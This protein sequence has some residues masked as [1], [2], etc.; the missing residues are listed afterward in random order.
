MPASR[1]AITS[2]YMISADGEE[3]R[4]QDRGTGGLR[5]R[6]R[7]RRSGNA[8]SCRRR[9]ARQ[10]CCA[11]RARRFI[12]ARCPALRAGWRGASVC[13]VG[14]AHFVGAA[15][16]RILARLAG[17][18]ADIGGELPDLV[19]G[20][21]PAPRRHAVGAAFGDRRGD[22][23][24]A[25]AVAPLVVHQRRAHAAAAMGMAADAIHLRVEQLALGDRRGIVVVELGARG[26]SGGGAPPP[27]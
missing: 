1:K 15:R 8:G 26:S 3:D 19:V 10:Q 11:R 16:H 2:R 20:Q 21:L 23:V 12:V 22:L 24:D 4:E 17:Q 9:A 14:V 13:G 7:R 5:R 18:R 27:G 25:P 6:R